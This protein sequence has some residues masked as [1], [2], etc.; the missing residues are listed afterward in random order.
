MRNS[1]DSLQIISRVTSLADT[2]ADCEP[3]IGR[4]KITVPQYDLGILLGKT[5]FTAHL[6]LHFMSDFAYET[7]LSCLSARYGE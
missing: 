6:H 1:T 5:N 2:G 4:K 3:P 7:R